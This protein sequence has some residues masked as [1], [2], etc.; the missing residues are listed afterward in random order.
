MHDTIITINGYEYDARVDYEFH[1]EEKGGRNEYGFPTEPDYPAH[2]EITRTKL[3]Y[4]IK[5]KPNFVVIDLPEQVLSEI[6]E[7]I[8]EEYH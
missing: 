2:V 3:N 8:L 4:S 5:G 7:E 1:K 6:E